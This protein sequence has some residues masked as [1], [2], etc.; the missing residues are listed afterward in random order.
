MTIKNR[1]AQRFAL[2]ALFSLI[3]SRQIGAALLVGIGQ[4]FTASTYGQDSFLLPPDANGAAGPNHFVQLI[5]GRYSVFSKTNGVRVANMTA[6]AF[7][8]QAGVCVAIT[9]GGT[10]SRSLD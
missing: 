5:N 6:L 3:A 8:L 4:N 9:C 1:I 7:W 2:A 10:R